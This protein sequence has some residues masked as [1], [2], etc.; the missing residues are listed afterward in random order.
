MLSHGGFHAGASFDLRCRHPAEWDFRLSEPEVACGAHRLV[1]SDV[2]TVMTP[3]ELEALMQEPPGGENHGRVRTEGGWRSL[4]PDYTP[5]LPFIIDNPEY[6]DVSKADHGT[7]ARYNH[8]PCRCDR[9]RSAW[10]VYM[11]EYRQRS[12]KP[13]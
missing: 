10:R 12:V 5:E 9:C 3:Y 13:E 7:V 2:G 8:G 4:E 6:R 1:A 11:R